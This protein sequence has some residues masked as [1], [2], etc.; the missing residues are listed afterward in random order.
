MRSMI[1]V[2]AA[3][4]S[5]AVFAQ[6]QTN[7]EQ[8]APRP[9]HVVA[10]QADGRSVADFVLT[11]C[12]SAVADPAAID[13]MAREK[14]WVRL[15]P[16]P[17][18]PS[19]A[20]AGRLPRSRWRVDGFFVT[21]WTP[22]DG[23]GN[24]DVPACFVGIRPSREVKRDE[25]FDAISAAL[26]LRPY[27]DTTSSNFR[28]ETYEIIGTKRKLLFSSSNE[29]GTMSGASIFTDNSVP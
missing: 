17:G 14:R 1:V 18:G 21:M 9:P 29:D 5:T 13:V 4:I 25:F 28:Q 19:R 2:I 26:D 3:V 22:G 10:R 7:V 16:P 11:T 20:V 24:P 23:S 12:L 27:K 8:P 6:E 15:P